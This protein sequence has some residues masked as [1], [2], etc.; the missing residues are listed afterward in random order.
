MSST[1][2]HTHF[3]TNAH[4]N[5]HRHAHKHTHRYC[6]KARGR[7]V[8]VSKSTLGDVT[9]DCEVV[10]SH[11]YAITHTHTHAHTYAHVRT[12]MRACTHTHTQTHTHTHISGDLD[13]HVRR[14]GGWGATLT[15]TLSLFFKH[16]YIV[17]RSRS[18]SRSLNQFNLSVYPKC[19]HLIISINHMKPALCRLRVVMS[20]GRSASRRKTR[21]KSETIRMFNSLP[22]KMASNFKFSTL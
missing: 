18:C 20:R 1:H 5:A 11:A 13:I 17:S 7:I 15:H 4:I 19:H 8:A 22:G 12:H 6:K 21:S 14:E 16:T 10:M 2:A 3:H 9:E